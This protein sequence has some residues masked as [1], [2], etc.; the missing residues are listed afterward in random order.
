MEPPPGLDLADADTA[1]RVLHACCGSTRW[2]ERML[3]RRPFQS[4]SALLAT[5]EDEWR[6][7]GPDDWREAFAHHPKIGD[8]E[9]LRTRF[10]AT[11]HLSERE[12]AGVSGAHQD[13][14][15]ALA[16]GNRAYEAKFG[17]IF[18]VCA[19]G[20]T[21]EEMLERLRAR[22][23]N[24]PETEI[25]IAAGEQEKITAIRLRGLSAPS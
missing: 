25:Q 17:Y 8:R 19:T 13:V 22:L 5:A 7:L 18:I 11:H 3:A 2:V 24:D 16:A 15:D 9:A 10:P 21:A 14:L 20:L 1:R 6:A 12:Q 23:P 4:E